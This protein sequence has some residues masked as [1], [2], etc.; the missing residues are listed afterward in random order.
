MRWRAGCAWCVS[1]EHKN[2]VWD[3]RVRGLRTEQRH[4]VRRHHAELVCAARHLVAR[5][6]AICISGGHAGGRVVWVRAARHFVA[7]EQAVWISGVHAGGTEDG[8]IE[9]SWRVVVL[10]SIQIERLEQLV[11]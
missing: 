4:C 5:E 9:V 11:G 7:R 2:K 1:F 3:C 6:Q 10:T 8:C